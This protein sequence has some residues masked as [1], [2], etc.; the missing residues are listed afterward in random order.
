MDILEKDRFVEVM[1]VIAEAVYNFHDRWGFTHA[2]AYKDQSDQALAKERIP[3][4]KKKSR[5]G[6]PPLKIFVKIPPISMRKQEI[7]CG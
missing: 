1:T 3:I 7:C 6:K 2:E 5:S 4:I